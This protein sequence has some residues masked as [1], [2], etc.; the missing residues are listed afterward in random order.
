MKTTHPYRVV[1]GVE[2]L[3][4]VYL[5][6]DVT[7]PPVIVWWHGGALIAGNRKEIRARHLQAYLAAGYAVVSPDYR[8][9]PETKLPE[10]AT[11]L[12]AA[13]T[14]VREA[15][16]GLH[17]LDPS[18]VAAIGHSAGGYLTLLAGAVV[19]PRLQALVSFYGY[20]DIIADWY[21][22]P[23]PCYCQEPMVS[24]REA[25]SVVNQTPICTGSP[26]EPRGRFYLYCRQQGRWPQEVV[27]FDPETQPEAFAPYC[28]L[29]NVDPAYPPTLLLHGDK[30]TDVPY[31]QSVLMAQEL[32]R[33]GLPHQLITIANGPHGFDGEDTA[34]A[35]AAFAK[36]IAF[37]EERLA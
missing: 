15:L 26:W 33:L 31:E 25:R 12:S 10:I 13:F 20:G 8:L 2:L 27:G 22:L 19:R 21:R 1:S 34:E 29:R 35:E 4:D 30:D 14:W 23:D 32:S 11:D 3:A 5:P 18:R 6:D 24:E 7:H 28:P 37:L 9:A 17:G 16:P 36:V